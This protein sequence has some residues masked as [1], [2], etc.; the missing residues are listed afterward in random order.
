MAKYK[1]KYR[2]GSRRKPNWGYRSS[3]GYFVTIC[4]KNREF[5]LGGI[6]V[7]SM[8]LSKIG[9]I[10]HNFWMEIPDHFPFVELGEFVVM[11]NHVHGIIII[12]KPRRIVACND[13]TN[14][15]ND[16]TDIVND[17]TIKPIPK[18]SDHQKNEKMAKISPKQGSLSTIIRSYKSAVT[19]NAREINSNF[20]WQPRFHDHIIRNEM[21]FERISNYIKNNPENW[22]VDKFRS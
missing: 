12:E 20:A 14:I 7:L 4:T 15:G 9:Q 21:E 1:N 18:Q 22:N 11:P 3:A 17:S 10:A 5:F 8:Q 13:S 16:S 2:G 6:P 19:K